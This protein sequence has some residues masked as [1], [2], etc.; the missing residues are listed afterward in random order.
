M[1]PYDQLNSVEL[2]MDAEPRFVCITLKRGSFDGLLHNLLGGRY[3]SAHDLCSEEEFYKA[4]SSSR[5]RGGR[6]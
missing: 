5:S 6:P 3:S 4:G 2:R 1:L